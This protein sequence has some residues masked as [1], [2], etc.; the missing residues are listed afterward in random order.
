MTIFFIIFSI[1]TILL[2]TVFL[3]IGGGNLSSGSVDFAAKGKEAG[4]SIKDIR[5]LKKTADILKLDKPL[6]LLGSVKNIDSAIAVISEMLNQSEYK[7]VEVIDLLEELF[8]YRNN[9]ELERVERRSL[10]SSSREINLNQQVKITIGNMDKTII[11]IVSHNS[12]N[13]LEIDLYNDTF[14]K[15]GINWDGPINVYFW[16][17]ND[18]GYFFESMVLE[19]LKS[20]KWRIAHSKTLIR[21]QKREN[22]RVDIELTAYVYKLDDISKKNSES[23]GF[24]GTFAQ[25]KNISESGVAFLINGVIDRDVSLKIEFKLNDS[26]VVICGIVIE[27]SHNKVNNISLIRLKIVDP[28]FEMLCIIRSFLYTSNRELYR[29]KDNKIAEDIENMEEINDNDS[30]EDVSEVEYLSENTGVLN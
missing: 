7:D 21:S 9:I 15:P 23:E 5:M 28:S 18:A 10:I 20:R 24:S 11:G 17:K 12:S 16:K 25:L 4:L 22:I 19:C 29:I 30:K 14:I 1:L 8:Q 6:T 2:I 27:S 3:Y 26:T 13:Y